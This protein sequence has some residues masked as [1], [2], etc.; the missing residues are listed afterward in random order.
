MDPRVGRFLGMDVWGGSQNSSITLN[1]YL[2]GNVNP[3]IFVDPIGLYSSRFG[4]QVDDYVCDEYIEWSMSVR[5]LCD[6][7]VVYGNAGEYYLPD[8]FD[9]T[10]RR[11]GEVKPVSPSGIASGILQI[12][13]YEREYGPH[14]YDR[15]WGWSPPS[16][17]IDRTRVYFFN[18][19]GVIF[20]TDMEAEKIAL[21]GATLDQLNNRYKSFWKKRSLRE[22][23][24]GGGGIIGPDAVAARVV[25]A[26]V[27]VF[28]IARI[29][30]ALPVVMPGLLRI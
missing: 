12:E 2:Y 27:G 15:I 13:K 3:T 21:M 16:T 29:A 1:K 22:A 8:I 5:V 9:Y 24:S 19:D 18:V 10:A 7:R 6:K 30:L 25:L 20:Y 28:A 14:G 26:G 17:V 23:S 11:F 4:M